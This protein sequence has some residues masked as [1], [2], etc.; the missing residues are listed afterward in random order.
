[1]ASL[2]ASEAP[3]GVFGLGVSSHLVVE[4][5]SVGE[6]GY[7][8]GGK[9]V[10]GSSHLAQSVE[11]FGGG[12]VAEQVLCCIFKLHGTSNE[13]RLVPGLSVVVVAE[14]HTFPT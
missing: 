11:A 3:W 8:D 14:G 5:R 1:V 7:G 13:D 4:S 10:T 9:R 12:N 2:L 6:G